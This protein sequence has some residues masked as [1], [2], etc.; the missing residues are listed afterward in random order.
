MICDLH[1]H[2]FLS[3]DSKADIDLTITKAI[4]LGM[5]YL[6][7]TDHHDFEYEDYTFEQDPFNYYKVMNSYKEKNILTKFELLIGIE[8]GLEKNLQ[9]S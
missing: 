8:I 6:A 1:V 4:D 7:I 2:T 5:K 3:A 9:K